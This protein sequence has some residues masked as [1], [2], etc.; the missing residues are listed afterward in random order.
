VGVSFAPKLNEEHME[1]ISK[2][3][4]FEK[5]SSQ[6]ILI[7]KN[8]SGSISVEGYQGDQVLVDINKLIKAENKTDLG[9]GIK[10]ISLG[11]INT[12][13]S[14]LLYTDSP[15]AT[16]TRKNGKISYQW[17]NDYG[18]IDYDFS[19]DYTV[20]IPFG[21]QLNVSTVNDGHVRITDTKSTVRAGNV[22]GSVYLEK[23]SAVSKASTVN[24]VVEC[25]IIAKPDKNCSFN[26]ING[27]IKIV[28]PSD[29]SADVTYKTMN[30]DFYT[31]FDIEILPFKVKRTEEKSKSGT[32][33]KI[34]RNPNFRIGG[35]DVNIKFR[36]INGDMILKKTK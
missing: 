3:L 20:K 29:L 31:N 36:T 33:Y 26:T 16:L 15:Y 35:G 1:K 2:Q 6:N 7:I 25:E 11:L 19:F 18:D 9:E 13:D 30:G 5:I 23:V 17:D 8:I 27:D 32:T 12:G 4:T 22:N 24:G 34:E 28:V 14:I 10:D 21:T